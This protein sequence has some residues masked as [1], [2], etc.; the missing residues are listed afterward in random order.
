M[1]R[2]KIPRPRQALTDIDCV[3]FDLD[4]TLV[5][6]VDLIYLSFDYAVKTVLGKELTR[7]QLLE[8]M[9]RPLLVQMQNFSRTEAGRLI[10]AYNSHN[11]NYHDKF[12]KAYP[13]TSQTLSWLR[14]EKN[15]KIGVVTSKKKELSRRG[16]EITGLLGYVEVLVAM[17][18]TTHH[19]PEPA[20]VRLALEELGRQ[21]RT[22]LFIGDSPFDLLAG[23]RAG[24]YTGAALWGPFSRAQL[25]EHEPDLAL[26]N[27][28][29]LQQW[30]K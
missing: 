14:N 7:D 6:T 21:A 13:Q 11:L 2:Q 9:G 28:G 16:L 3:L 20:P 19:K 10:E 12:I 1:E 25:L 23:R 15:V 5:D 27:I 30:L 24:T 29:E 18:D 4:G 17:E 22:A 8:N 26:E